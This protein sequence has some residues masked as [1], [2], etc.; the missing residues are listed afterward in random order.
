MKLLSARQ[1]GV[2]FQSGSCILYYFYQKRLQYLLKLHL[3]KVR[4]KE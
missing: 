2:P 3:T 1:Q 4:Q